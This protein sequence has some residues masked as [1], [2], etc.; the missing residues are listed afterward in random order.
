MEDSKNLSIEEGTITFWIKENSI[1]FNDKKITQLFDVNP[2]GGSI[3]MVKDDDNKLKVMFVVLGKGRVDIEHDV[4]EVNPSNRHMVAF[5][6]SLKSNQLSLYLDGELIES[7]E[8]N[9]S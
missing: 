6:W 4:S 7:K 2:A 1:I 3:F 8:I 9:L 5:T